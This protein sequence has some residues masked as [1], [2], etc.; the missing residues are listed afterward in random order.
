MTETVELM[1][2]RAAVVSS[3]AT[4]RLLRFERPADAPAPPR[5]PLL[6]V[7]SMINRWYVV[8]LRPGASLVGALAAAGHDVFCLDWGIAEAEDR[9]LTWDDVVDRLGRA[10]ARVRRVTGAP[11]VG[12]LGYCMG[13]TLAA[14]ATALQPERVAALVNLAGPI[15][16]SLGGCLRAM[17]D[18]RWFDADAIADAGNVHPVQMQAGFVALRPTGELAKRV[19]GIDP[20][21][22]AWASDNI[23]FPG[24]AYRTYI[25][26][27]YQDNRLIS[28]GHRV[29]GR[30]VDLREIRCPLLVIVAERDAICPPAAATA[31]I[32]HCRSADSSVLS[33]P[34]GHVG[35]VVG[36]RASK[37]LYPALAAWLR[38]RL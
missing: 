1:P 32:D 13:A 2:T 35:A 29:R 31:L 20:A 8:D 16:F 24:E 21:L 38:E 26:E 6:V 9:Y 33:V 37:Q 3:E 34:G 5:L 27:L 15:D 14:I 17:V 23:P 25:R 30:A 18:P 4:A 11:Q 19:R 22:D 10:I 28:G 12:L 7:P 36:S